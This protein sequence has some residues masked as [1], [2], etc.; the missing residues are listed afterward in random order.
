[1]AGSPCLG[2]ERNKGEYCRTKDDFQNWKNEYYE[3]EL[4]D[5]EKD[6]TN[7][8]F[9][10]RVAQSEGILKNILDLGDK[11]KGSDPKTVII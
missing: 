11:C 1:M 8:E 5:L 9:Q 2:C 7:E 4:K 10:K 6:P 3:G